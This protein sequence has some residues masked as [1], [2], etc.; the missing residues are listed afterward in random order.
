MFAVIIDL[1]NHHT[2]DGHY[3]I[4]KLFKQLKA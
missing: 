1:F 2:Y 4:G 3:R